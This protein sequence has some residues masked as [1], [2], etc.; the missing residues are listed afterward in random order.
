MINATQVQANI[1]CNHSNTFTVTSGNNKKI[2]WGG[3]IISVTRSYRPYSPPQDYQLVQIFNRMGNQLMEIEKE[4][5]KA[6]PLKYNAYL[7]VRR[8]PK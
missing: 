3:I 4:T 1:T 2:I 7:Y 8:S 5:T 6:H